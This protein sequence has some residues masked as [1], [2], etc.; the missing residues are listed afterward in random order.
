MRTTIPAMQKSNDARRGRPA[1]GRMTTPAS[2]TVE[3][4]DSRPAD[5]SD[6][7][8]RGVRSGASDGTQWTRA[9]RVF[10]VGV[11]FLAISAAAVCLLLGTVAALGGGGVGFLGNTSYASATKWTLAAESI[12]VSYS[13]PLPSRLRGRESNSAAGGRTTGIRTGGNEF[14]GAAGQTA[15]PPMGRDGFAAPQ[16]TSI[17]RAGSPPSPAVR[18]IDG[19]RVFRHARAGR[20][21][22]TASRHHDF[23]P[24]IYVGCP[25]ANSLMTKPSAHV[26]APV[27]GD[28]CFQAGSHRNHRVPDPTATGGVDPRASI[29]A[30]QAAR[31]PAIDGATG[32]ASPRLFIEPAIAS[33][34]GRCVAVPAPFMH[35]TTRGAAYDCEYSTR[36]PDGPASGVTGRGALA[37]RLPQAAHA[38][39]S[40]DADRCGPGEVAGLISPV[41]GAAQVIFPKP[42]VTTPFSPGTRGSGASSHQVAFERDSKRF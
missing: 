32:D 15:F 33:T 22:C 14:V 25:G 21:S 23:H 3:I 24:A 42:F 35:A 27:V 13:P 28:A 10:G 17:A 16:P 36:S 4:R 7:V 40:R 9:G 19:S 18:A 8:E 20:W 34:R 6:G 41:A 38:R 37:A 5:A 39:S 31:N 12:H 30:D 29:H 1:L 11:S 2:R 26:L